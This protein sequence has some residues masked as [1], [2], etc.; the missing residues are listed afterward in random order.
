ME[1]ARKLAKYT[2]GEADLLRK[3]MGKKKPEILAK[4][5]SKFLAG[6]R[7]NGFSEKAS[8]TLWEI[9]VPFAGYGFNK[10]HTAGYALVSYWTAYL[11]ANYPAE[12]MAALLSG[13]T[14]KPEKMAL[15][16]AEC[17]RMGIKVL[18]PDVNESQAEFA[19]V[20]GNIRCGLA[21]VRNVGHG[22]VDLIIAARQEKGRF[23]SFEDFLT[24]VPAEVCSTR[25]VE[26][27]I[28]A[29]A[30]DSLGVTRLALMRVHKGA[31]EIMSKM[32]KAESAGQFDLF[33][34]APES[35]QTASPLAHLVYP[36]EE[37]NRRDLLAYERDMLG[38]YVSAHPLDGA[39]HLLRRAARRS[40]GH[41][42][43]DPPAE[44]EVQLAGLITEVDRRT[45]KKGEPWA[46]VTVEDVDG[47]ME[48]LFFAKAY[49]VN[50]EYLMQ[51][52]VV[53]IKGRVNWRDENVSVFGSIAELIDISSAEHSPSSGPLPYVIKVEADRVTRDTVT[54]MRSSLAAHRGRTP[55]QLVLC[56]EGTETTFAL[57]DYAVEPSSLLLGELKGIPGVS[58]QW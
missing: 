37:Y 56:A 27:L 22:V 44:G 31:V 10:S 1:I 21:G 38:L 49:A 16:L 6:M 9:M 42:L 35:A 43:A 52:N 5:E 57:D 23:T 47:A 14:T 54:E 19:A 2:F 7:E 41:L 12:F 51:D 45:N 8:R 15:Y 40:I 25:V 55:V 53:M 4:E 24:K 11:K 18:P 39:E 34:A 33:G 17:R 26:S 36:P 48:V 28:K 13:N 46:I 30:F 20:D 50:F 58:V 3:A 32:K 29:G